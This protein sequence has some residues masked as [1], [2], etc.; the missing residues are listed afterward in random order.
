[1]GCGEVSNGIKH[2][3]R[4]QKKWEKRDGRMSEAEGNVGEAGRIRGGWGGSAKLQRGWGSGRRKRRW[5]ETEA[6]G[7]WGLWTLYV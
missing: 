4:K 3:K 5:V 7:F 1:M 6:W 2:V